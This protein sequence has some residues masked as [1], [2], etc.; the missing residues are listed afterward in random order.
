MIGHMIAGLDY[1][2]SDRLSLGVKA[3]FGDAFGEFR[4]GDNPWKPLR[5]HGSTVGPPGT[6]GGDLPVHY[7]VSADNLDMWGIS[8]GIKYFWE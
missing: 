3:R 7:E 2:L 6:P 1:A 8:L 5:G 4:D